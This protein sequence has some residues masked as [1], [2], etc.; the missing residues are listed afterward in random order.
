MS[1][2]QLTLLDSVA[3]E[4]TELRSTASRKPLPLDTST[5]TKRLSVSP[6]TLNSYKRRGERY[7]KELEG[8]TVTVEY[9]YTRQRRDYWRVYF[10][11]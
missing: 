1:D 6:S 10:E 2:R 8:G 3:S 4:L 11:Q 7:Q 5:V 9:A